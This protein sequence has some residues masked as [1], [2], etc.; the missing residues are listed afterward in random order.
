[1]S[2]A[3]KRDHPASSEDGSSPK[4]HHA[5]QDGHPSS[6]S[7]SGV[8]NLPESQS[9]DIYHLPELALHGPALTCFKEGVQAIRGSSSPSLKM[10]FEVLHCLLIACAPHADLDR[11]TLAEAADIFRK[12]C[13]GEALEA[14][15]KQLY[16]DAENALMNHNVDLLLRNRMYFP[17]FHL[18]SIVNKT[19]FQ[20]SSATRNRKALLVCNHLFYTTEIS[21]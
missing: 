11:T 10:Q 9:D 19:L 21:S 13:A 3:Q 7:Q 20:A 8:R 4:R 16:T 5:S 18:R 1:M 6:S 17:A 15:K 14:D 2:T 12:G